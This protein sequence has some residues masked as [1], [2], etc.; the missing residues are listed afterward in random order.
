MAR[1][2][3]P[4][5]PRKLRDRR[6]ARAAFPDVALRALA[7][8]DLPQIA[9]WLATPHVAARWDPPHV[10]LPAMVRDIDDA[11]MSPFIIIA[12]G[13][14]V[15]FLQ[16]YAATNTAF[17]TGHDLPHETFGLDLFIGAADALRQGYGS[18]SLSLAAAHLLDIPG[19]ARVQGDPSPDNK[20]S[21]RAFAKAGF[22]NRGEITTPDGPAIYMAI[23]GKR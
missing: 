5:V 22:E 9:R 17:W 18:A 3:A 13:R 15:G 4:V 6:I 21:L 12:R 10:A 1:K 8:G 16:I 2:S 23:E 7:L 20:A 11:D 14:A 19:V